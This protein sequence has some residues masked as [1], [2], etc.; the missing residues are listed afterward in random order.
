MVINIEIKNRKVWRS[1]NSFVVTLPRN[2]KEGDLISGK[3]Q[4]IEGKKINF[5]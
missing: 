2:V 1:G 5:Q 3:L 4:I